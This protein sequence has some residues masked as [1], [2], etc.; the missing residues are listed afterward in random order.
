[1]TIIGSLGAIRT[2]ATIAGF[3]ALAAGVLCAGAFIPAVGYGL[4]AAGAIATAAL[5]AIVFFLIA[6]L[7]STILGSLGT[8]TTALG[9]LSTAVGTLTGP[10]GT[11]G[12]SVG[13]VS[14]ILSNAAAPSDVKRS[15]NDVDQALNTLQNDLT[16]N[17]GLFN[18]TATTLDGRAAT[19]QNFLDPTPAG[20]PVS[21]R[22]HLED[23]YQQAVKIY[24]DAITA[25]QA[26]IGSGVWA[27]MVADPYNN[28][29][30]TPNN[31][32]DRKLA[33]VGTAQG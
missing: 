2:G 13:T 28:P 7:I 24:D 16:N 4:L 30:I 22:A 17:L 8:V 21:P 32:L 25:L 14:G 31:T 33:C 10:L 6:G 1:L 5:L 29:Q 9:T 19:L 18:A 11:V 3:A 27:A 15:L 20:Q 23:T 26:L 12:A